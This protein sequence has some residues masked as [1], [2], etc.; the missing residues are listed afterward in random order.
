M[1]T[2]KEYYDAD[3]SHTVSLNRSLEFKVT[4]LGN[5]SIDTRIHLDFF[6]KAMFA[7][8][9]I[10][11]PELSIK[12][13]TE[14]IDE[15][16]TLWQNGWPSPDNIRL[17]SVKL[18]PGALKISNNPF[19]VE[20]TFFGGTSTKHDELLFSGRLYLYI[21]SH[22]TLADQINL[23]SSLTNKNLDPQIRG[24]DFAK[25]RDKIQ[26]P[27]AFISHDSHDKESIAKPIALG[28]QKLLVPVW[29][30]EFSLTVGAKLRES[31]E[32]GIKQCKR[33]IL[34]VTKSFLSNDGWTKAEFDSVFTKEIVEKGN[35]ILPIWHQVTQKEV[36]EYS[37]WLANI[38]AIDWKLGE[39]EVI[40]KLHREIIK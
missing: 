8:F 17:V 29:Y 34:I 21:D 3:F 40:N 6:T 36:Y 7:S 22:F 30:D 31:I 16:D 24:H 9:Y 37:P 26:T 28:L 25:M 10:P 23:K 35:V 18:Y 15:I 13:L 38:F 32:A 27:L 4:D 20:S 33:C 11:H 14:I 1:A 12:Q 39:D 19:F 2:L 5:I